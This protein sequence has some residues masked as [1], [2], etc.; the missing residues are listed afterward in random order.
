MASTSSS[1]SSTLMTYPRRYYYDVFVSFRGKDTRFNFTD[2]LFATF[3]RK[4]IITFRDDT[5]LNKGESIAPELLSA[6]QA[7]QIYVVVFSK[8]YATSTWCLRE[9][10]WILECAQLSGKRVLPVFY[11]VDP[12]EVRY[13]KGSYGEAFL[14]HEQRFQRDSEM[15]Q[16]WREDLTQ[17]ANLSGWDLRDK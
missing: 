11:D 5:K 8:N 15:L 6:I 12:S 17:V 16:R 2:H 9:L 3:Q 1:S 10:E 7:S 13:Q 14:K 4:G